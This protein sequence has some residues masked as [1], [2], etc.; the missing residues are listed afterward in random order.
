MAIAG[1]VHKIE[2]AGRV[3]T[4]RPPPLNPGMD[5]G[6]SPL[7]GHIRGLLGT[8]EGR[9]IAQ[10]ALRRVEAFLAARATRAAAALAVA[11]IKTPGIADAAVL[12]ELRGLFGAPDPSAAGEGSGPT[13]ATSARD[14]GL[15]AEATAGRESKP[16]PRA[17]PLSSIKLASVSTLKVVPGAAP[18]AAPKGS[19]KAAPNAAKYAKNSPKAAPNATRAAPKAAPGSHHSAHFGCRGGH[20]TAPN[21]GRERSRLKD[22][23]VEMEIVKAIASSREDFSY[24]DIGCAEG[25]ITAAVAEELGTPPGRSHACDIVPRSRTHSSSSRRAVLTA[26]LTTKSRSTSRLCS[27]RPTTSPTPR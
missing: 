21:K 10:D 20:N 27:W 12:K 9:P 6:L 2:C 15:L 14:G 11:A 7:F 3:C 5:A 26:S 25:R 16:A 8:R 4:I 23:A 19:P 13:G 18:G 22:V 24:L 17:V 1:A